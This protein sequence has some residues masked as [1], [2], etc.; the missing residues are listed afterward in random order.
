MVQH[1]DVRFS[2]GG[3]GVDIKKQDDE[4]ILPH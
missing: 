3:Y 1:T 2:M 4:W